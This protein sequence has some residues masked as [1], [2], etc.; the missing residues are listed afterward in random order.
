M[1]KENH[2]QKIKDLLLGKTI[3]KVS[4]DM[5]S[6]KYLEPREG[7]VWLSDVGMQLDFEDTC[8][9]FFYDENTDV[10]GAY[11]RTLEDHL[12]QVDHFMI[13]T[14]ESNIINN[15]IIGHVIHDV[16]IKWLTY[17]T[18]DHDFNVIEEI[19]TPGE[20]IISLDNEQKIQ[21][22]SVTLYF[23][24]KTAQVKDIVYNLEGNVWVSFGEIY[25]IN[26]L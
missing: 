17:Q 15:D 16:E 6:D 3:T 10:F 12:D 8:V 1:D 9:A 14:S 21:V 19:Q 4:L 2:G 18:T 7:S 5:I 25:E 20:Y 13:D 26:E 11:P 23:E 24:P 22:A